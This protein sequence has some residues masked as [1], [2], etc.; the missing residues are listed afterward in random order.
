MAIISPATGDKIC[1]KLKICLHT[2]H[3]PVAGS[4]HISTLHLPV[5]G[6]TDEAEKTWESG[7]SRKLM[8][9]TKMTN[10]SRISDGVIVKI[11]VSWIW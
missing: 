7:N 10:S 6:S 4:P 1:D 11:V 2:L 5:A 9:D 3:L 8:L